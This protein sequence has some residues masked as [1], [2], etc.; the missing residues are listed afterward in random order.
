[1]P[2]HPL[3]HRRV[4]LLVAFVAIVLAVTTS[5]ALHQAFVDVLTIA[6]RL[7]RAYPRAGML[8][9][10]GLASLSA[11]LSFFSSSALVPVGVYVWGAQQTMLMLWVGG[12]L[13]G[14]AGYWMARTL[15]RRIVKRLVP[16]APFRRYET[17]FRTRAQ[18]RTVLL[19]RL[20]L[21]SELPSYVL[22]VL[23][24]PFR[25]Y[26]PMMLLG[27]IP[28]VFFAVYL[29]ETLL[30]RNG[31]VFAIALCVGVG[32]TVLAFRALQREMRSDAPPIAR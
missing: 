6:E 14:T 2:H 8:A 21:Q 22:G 12:V 24:Y 28:F 18:W 19:F 26:L 31:V 11:M 17:F 16:E 30:E 9:F 10:V 23:R 15:G 7:M 3:H 29:G 20:A 27:E 32:L 5:D 4:A 1:M 25:R 13:G